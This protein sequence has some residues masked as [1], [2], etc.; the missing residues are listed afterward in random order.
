MHHWHHWHDQFTK[1]VLRDALGRASA[2]ETEVE[3]LAATQKIDLYTV[4]DPARAAERAELGLLGALAAEPSLFEPFHATP[5]LRKVRRCVNKQLTWHHEL[6]RRARAGP[7]GTGS[8][9]AGPGGASSEAT[10]PEVPFPALVVIGP[11]VPATVLDAYGCRPTGPG[12]YAAVWGLALRVVV[13]A[14]LPRTRET[15]LLRLLGKGKQLQAA[16]ADLAE[17]P[18][19]ARERGI[20]MPLL[21]HFQLAASESPPAE[22]DDV[23]AEIR[24]WFEDYQRKLR[25]QI[26]QEGRSQI[27][28]E[29]RNEGER[30][31]LLR[32]L[33]AR[34]GEL[35]AAAIARVEAAEP[36]ELERWGE[37]MFDAA[38]LDEV[39]AEPRRPPLAPAS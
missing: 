12:V 7:G 29:G 38:T 8:G 17:L 26:L 10:V 2:A 21:V 28:Q 30:S 11:G 31:L 25:S 33:R 13:L 24:A 5:T 23:S 15:L 22:E 6:E 9:G 1:N 39:L 19:D 36:A 4:P 37:R 32:L 3:V 35:P 20:V 34:F 14:E 18:E 16:L 27:L